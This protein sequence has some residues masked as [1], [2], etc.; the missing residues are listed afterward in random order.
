[1]ILQTLFI[2]F[3]MNIIKLDAIPSTNDFLKQLS[4]DFTVDDFTV[5][6]ADLQTDGKGQMGAKWVSEKS[7]N[8]IVSV[9]INNVIKNI[10][11]IFYLNIAVATAIYDGLNFFKI[12][13][14]SIKWANDILSGNKKIAGI[15]IENIIKSDRDIVTI[16]GFGINVNQSSFENL[17]Q[18]SS[19]K[20]I[21]G[22][23]FEK[24]LIL[25][26]IIDC[27]KNNLQLLNA[28]QQ[29]VLWHKYNSLLFKKGVPVVFEQND[30][31]FMGIINGVT[32]NGRLELLL[33][34]D[35]V[36]QFE[37]K[38]IKMHY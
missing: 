3:L 10:D 37:I 6:T 38:E 19:L 13:D 16:I 31:K 24:E 7:K 15:L 18:A 28:H 5:V 12:P 14:L 17:P 2:L 32:A 21:M 34:D 22:Q 26:K 20:N 9:L 33:A 8:L 35:I 4:I 25:I 30:F 29:L 1:M 27:L 11:E 36:K 23:E